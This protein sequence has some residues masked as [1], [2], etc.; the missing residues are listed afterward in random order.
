MHLAAAML[1]DCLD[2]NI[3]CIQDALSLAHSWLASHPPESCVKANDPEGQNIETIVFDKLDDY[4]N[5]LLCAPSR[6]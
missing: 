3:S 2:N 5:G 6:D 4:N 1:N